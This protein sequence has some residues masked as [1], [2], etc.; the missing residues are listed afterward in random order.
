MRKMAAG[1]G[2]L[3]IGFALFAQVAVWSLMAIDA[4]NAQSDTDLARRNG[5][6][7]A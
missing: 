4:A 6:G 1:V 2:E 7:C 3:R 5:A